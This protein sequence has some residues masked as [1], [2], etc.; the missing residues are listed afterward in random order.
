MTAMV[1]ASAGVVKNLRFF[2]VLPAPVLLEALLNGF[3]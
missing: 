1:T 2:A 3:P